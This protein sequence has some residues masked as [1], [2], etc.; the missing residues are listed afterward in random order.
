MGAYA[1]I[2]DGCGGDVQYLPDETNP[3]GPWI[4]V[5][6]KCKKEPAFDYKQSMEE[7]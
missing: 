1:G 2:H 7:K 3:D 6:L 4:P 5:C